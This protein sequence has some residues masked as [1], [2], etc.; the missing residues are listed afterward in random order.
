M[1]GDGQP[2]FARQGVYVYWDRA[3]HE[4]LYLGLA[5]DLLDRFAQ[6]NG[7]RAHSGG[8]KRAKIDEYFESHERL[9][10][11]VLIQGKAVAILEQIAALD[12][13]LGATAGDLI[14]V[15]E[16]Q[17]IEM[18]R[19]LYGGWPAWNGTGG[20]REGQRWAAPA[21]APLEVLS[22][23][24]SSLFAARHSLRELVA[25]FRLRL[26][27]GK[28]H[29]ARMRA[30]LDAHEVVKPWPTEGEEVKRPILRLLMLRSGHIV[31]ELDASDERI[32]HWLRIGGDPASWAAEAVHW[33][34]RA[35]SWTAGKSVSDSDRA[36]YQLLDT[37]ISHGAPPQHIA[38]TR[39]ILAGG[40]LDRGLRLP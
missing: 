28:I 29:A 25:D 12:P 38:A 26:F 4:I 6:H 8:N 18:H 31:D 19:L 35:A 11:S 30:V 37:Q 32:T 36:I 20:S 21:P 17:L 22:G 13:A 5:S 39:D 24:R 7:L 34:T 15:G 16:G 27:E 23:R 10:F 14:A 2:D 1:L 33:R 3:S 40:Y 9:G